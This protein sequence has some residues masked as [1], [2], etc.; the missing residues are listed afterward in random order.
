MREITLGSLFD[1]LGG[2]PLAGIRNGIRPLWA[3]DIEPYPIAVTRNHFPNMRHVGSVT[4]I[5]G[6]ELEPVDI[7]TFGSPC[8]DLSVAGKQAGIHEGARSSLF[9]EAIRII[10][11]MREKDIA[12][13]R[14]VDAVRPRFAVWENVPGAFSSNKGKDFQAVLQ[15]FCEIGGGTAHI[16]PLPPNGKWLA[17]GNIVGNGFSLAWRVLDAAGW[18]VPQRRKRIFLVADFAG[19]RAAEV[20]LNEDRLHGH[21][22]T[23]GEAGQGTAA[24]A[25][26]STGRSNRNEWGGCVLN[27]QGGAVMDVSDKSMTLRAQEHGHQP[28][29]CEEREDRTDNCKCLNPWDCQSKRQY[30]VDGV[31]RT[32]DA[33]ESDG[34]QAHGVC[35]PAAFMGGQ[36]AKAGS[37]AYAGDGSTPTIKSAPSGGNTVPDVVYPINTM[38]ATRGGKD[39][40]RTA[41]GVGEANDPQFTLGAAHEHAVCYAIE[42]NTVDRASNKNGKGY[43]EG[44]SPTLN[45]QDKHAVTYAIEGNGQRESHQGDGYSETDTMYTL[46]TIERHAVAFQNSGDR[47][48]PSV[49]VSDKAYCIPANPMSDRQQAVCFQQ[50]QREEVRDMGGVSGALSAE[51]GSHQQ[52]YVCYKQSGFADYEEGVGTL[53]ASGGDVGGVLKASSSRIYDA[54]GNGDGKTIPTLTGDHENRITDYT[55]LC[56]ERKVDE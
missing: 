27:D 24:H 17:A 32:L 15:A 10:R 36:G 28:I 54:R 9:F 56:V 51:P 18:G 45:T 33:G 7:I 37:I 47:C 2:F 14:P 19:E 49:S 30:C 46:N 22:A 48:N 13:G 4:E 53:K 31:Y 35:Y 40:G 23:G 21:P 6:T 39:D 29:V 8:Q 16:V 43:C 26:R 20:L 34:G 52:N 25:E 3:S 50:N 42:G 11:E 38:V 12:D 44:V 41:F 1:G 5:S 55:A